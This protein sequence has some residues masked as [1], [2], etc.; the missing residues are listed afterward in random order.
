[1]RR[2]IEAI[3]DSRKPGLAN[4]ERVREARAVEA[5][6]LVGSPEAR[7]LLEKL[8]KGPADATL[9]QDAKAALDRLSRKESARP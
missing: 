3:L 8:T 5:L 6:E 4:P 2:R 1:M 9:T 7:E